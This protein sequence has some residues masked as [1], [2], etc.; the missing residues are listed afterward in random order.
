M[1]GCA[2]YHAKTK[3]ELMDLIDKDIAKD[4]MER[5]MGMNKVM[6]VMDKPESC[7]KCKL[8]KCFI[9]RD[10]GACCVTGRK[11]NV[12]TK[13]QDWC[14]LREVPEKDNESYFPDEYLDGFASGYNFC[15]DEILGGTET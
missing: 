1:T 5:G 7:E 9:K 11:F 13:V 12:L 3:N 15:I 6:L 2:D 4:R 8:S 14:P 10:V